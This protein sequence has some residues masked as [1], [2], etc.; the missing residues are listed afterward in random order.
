[1]TTIAVSRS[2]RMMASDSSVT[3]GSARVPSTPKMWRL[4]DVIVGTAGNLSHCEAFV[5]WLGSGD[6]ARPKGDY[7][8]LCLYRDGRISWWHPGHR[9]KFIDDDYFAIGS[10]EAYALGAF[11]A[12]K[13]MGLPLDPRI[14]VECAVAREINSAH[15]IR[16]LRWKG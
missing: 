3:I 14:A 10:G 5:E 9:E 8:A 12:L 2:L 4:R 1:M 16:Y 6:G 15:P 11:E 7:C 13:H